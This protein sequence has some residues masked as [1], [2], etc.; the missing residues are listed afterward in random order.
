MIEYFHDRIPSNFSVEQNWTYFT[1]SLKQLMAKHVPQKRIS[2]K[3]HCPWVTAPIR[4]AIKKKKK[5]YKKAKANTTG[6][7]LNAYV[8]E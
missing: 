3:H 6:T 8:E 5:L 4:R 7:N 2:G 1:K